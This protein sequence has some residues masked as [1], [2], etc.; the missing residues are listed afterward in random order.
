M[1]V[2]FIYIFIVLFWETYNTLRLLYGVHVYE[3]SFLVK[4]YNRPDN[5]MLS[6]IMQIFPSL[7][8]EAWAP[9]FVEK[10]VTCWD[11]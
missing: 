9:L 5:C 6:T 4:I 11:N 1:V 10:D 8:D 3:F 2:R 7:K